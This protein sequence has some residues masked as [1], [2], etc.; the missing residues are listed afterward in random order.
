[1]I[2][3]DA[4]NSVFTILNVF[5]L[6]KAK[7]AIRCI[8]HQ[9]DFQTIMKGVKV[10]NRLYDL[11]LCFYDNCGLRVRTS[12][13]RCVGYDQ[14]TMLIFVWVVWEQLQKAGIYPY[15]GKPGANSTNGLDWAQV[16]LSAMRQT[17]GITTVSDN[18]HLG[19]W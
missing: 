16:P 6:C 11:I 13:T 18:A 8:D 15:E 19:D 7:D 1:M 9:T 10:S 4:K 3:Q 17:R 2:A 12:K 5:G 14:Y